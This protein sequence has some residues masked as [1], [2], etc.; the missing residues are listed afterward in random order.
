MSGW[1]IL[2]WLGVA[3]LTVLRVALAVGIV[4][5]VVL[6]VRGVWH[7]RAAQPMS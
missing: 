6:I 5:V 4:V 3:A 1:V 2:A 7:Y